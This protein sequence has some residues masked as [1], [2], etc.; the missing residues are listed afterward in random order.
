M[1]PVLVDTSIWIAHFRKGESYLVQLLE[2]EVVLCH[3]F[4][5]GELACGNLKNRQE[6]FS[7]L[8]SLPQ[9]P[10]A[11]NDEVLHFIEENRLMG[12]GLG[13]VDVHLLASARLAEA[14]IWTLDK[15]LCKAGRVLDILYSSGSGS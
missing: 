8:Q 1:K 4:V 7:L 6:I 5:I 2:E 9:A 14:Q 12:K 15:A 13:W 11:E 10:Q 3:P